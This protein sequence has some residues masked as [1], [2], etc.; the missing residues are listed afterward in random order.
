MTYS[1][2]YMWGCDS[3][4]GGPYTYG[5]GTSHVTCVVLADPATPTPAPTPTPATPAAALR[6]YVGKCRYGNDER[7]W[8]YGDESVFTQSGCHDLCSSNLM[9][10]RHL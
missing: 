7:D 6:V 4:T 9:V 8:L 5:D 1:S 10:L 2:S 3:Y